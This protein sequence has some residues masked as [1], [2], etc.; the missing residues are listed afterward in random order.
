MRFSTCSKPKGGP[1]ATHQ[2]AASHTSEGARAARRRGGPGG[3][4]FRRAQGAGH[5]G[6]TWVGALAACGR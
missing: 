2:R 5:M 6:V 4:L 3:Q 1:H